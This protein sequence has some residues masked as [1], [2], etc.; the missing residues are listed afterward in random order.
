[1]ETERS[2]GLYPAGLC[3]L[4][5]MTRVRAGALSRKK[6][7]GPKVDRG[8]NLWQPK[9]DQVVHF[10]FY[11]EMYNIYVKI[12]FSYVEPIISWYKGGQD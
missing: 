6:W 11:L 7:T 9:V 1:M 3:S 8:S 5:P 4:V 10:S 2:G 12:K